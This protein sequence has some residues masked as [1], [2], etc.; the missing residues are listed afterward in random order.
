MSN[1]EVF[2]SIFEIHHSLFVIHFYRL[3]VNKSRGEK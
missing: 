3:W 2:G 1:D